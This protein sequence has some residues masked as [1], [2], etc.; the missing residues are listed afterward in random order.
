MGPWRVMVSVGPVRSPTT[1]PTP[2]MWRSDPLDP[3]PPSDLDGSTTD[4]LEDTVFFGSRDLEGRQADFSASVALD[5]DPVAVLV[6]WTWTT[7]HSYA[8]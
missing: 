5:P 1:L 2:D 3:E 4:M 6:S 7:R 8:W